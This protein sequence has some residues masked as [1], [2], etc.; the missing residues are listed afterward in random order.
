MIGATQECWASVQRNQ[1]DVHQNTQKEEGEPK[2]ELKNPK[3]ET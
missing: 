2:C 3:R 1:Q